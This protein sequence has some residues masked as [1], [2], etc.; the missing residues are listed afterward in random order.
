MR[1]ARNAFRSTFTEKTK[2]NSLKYGGSDLALRSGAGYGRHGDA[3]ARSE[4]NGVPFDRN[5]RQPRQQRAFGVFTA[6]HDPADSA[7]A[8]GT[9]VPQGFFDRFRVALQANELPVK[10]SEVR[11]SAEPLTSTVRRLLMAALC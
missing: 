8:G 5:E 9:V 7:G 11:I 3:Y 10:L 1:S 6:A 2:P 4:G